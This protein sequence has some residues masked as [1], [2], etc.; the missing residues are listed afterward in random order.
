M[1]PRS[2]HHRRGILNA[3]GE[4][5]VRWPHPVRSPSC[6]QNSQRCVNWSTH[7]TFQPSCQPTSE[8]P[9]G[10]KGHRGAAEKRCTDLLTTT[11]HIVLDVAHAGGEDA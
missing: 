9:Q 7:C 10:G 11:A 2:P 8:D 1:L 3:A 6:H 5:C 4:R